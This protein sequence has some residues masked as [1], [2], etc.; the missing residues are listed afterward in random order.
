MG[1]TSAS[2]TAPTERPSKAS[3]ESPTLGGASIQYI[4]HTLQ[5]RPY[6]GAAKTLILHVYFQKGKGLFAGVHFTCRD[7]PDP[8]HLALL[9]RITA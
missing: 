5:A 4:K 6:S 2:S 1:L 8:R 9:L 3:S 7:Q